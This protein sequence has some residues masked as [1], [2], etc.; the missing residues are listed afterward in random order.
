MNT[1]NGAG[2][3]ELLQSA[4][5]PAAVSQE[6]KAN[7]SSIT[8]AEAETI[9]RQRQ[10]NLEEIRS[11]VC[12]KFYNEIGEKLKNEKRQFEQLLNWQ[13]ARDEALSNY[14]F[15]LNPYYFEQKFL[16]V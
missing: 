3:T 2:K 16:G 4:E 13:D 9:Y 11:L 8:T 5:M 15:V 10:G 14:S 12:L 6:T 1:S 7:S